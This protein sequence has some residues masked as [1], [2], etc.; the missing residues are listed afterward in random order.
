MHAVRSDSFAGV[1]RYLTY[2]APELARRGHDVLV[3]GGDPERMARDLDGAGVAHVDAA[4]VADVARQ[5]VRAPAGDVLH[6]HMT[7]AELAAWAVWPVRRG[8]TVTTMHFAAP[9]GGSGAK[10][11]AFGLLA[12]RFARQIA[13]SEFVAD[14]V[15]GGLVVIPNGVPDRRPHGD[16]GPREHVVLAAQR[17]EPEKDPTTALRGWASSGLAGDGWRLDVAGAGRL[18]P[19]LRA[20]ATELGIAA[21]VSFV[22]RVDDLDVRMA[23]A[24]IFL[25]TAPREPFG[26]S[27]TEAMS[28][29]C[30]IVAADGGGHRELLRG[31]DPRQLVAPGSPEALGERLRLLADDVGLRDRLGRANR[32]RYL[33]EYTLDAHV[34]RLEGVYGAVTTRG[35]ARR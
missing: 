13:I 5:L 3:I 1:E 12:P 34:D 31:T 9:R 28:F 2:V 17:L 21:S 26:L 30:P 25:A 6:T 15:G 32:A 10:A 33:A 7:A 8:P 4:T 19:Q 29:G 20:L 18:E 35:G 22:G 24:G 16:D 14:A 11:R 27:V 23:R